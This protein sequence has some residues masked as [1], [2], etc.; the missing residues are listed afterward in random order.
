[1]EIKTLSHWWPVLL[2]LVG[3]ERPLYFATNETH[4]ISR[5]DAK[6][7]IQGQLAIN[8][9][10]EN[11]MSYQAS[12][13][14]ALTNHLALR[15]SWLRGGDDSYSQ[16]FD[17]GRFD[18]AHL[19]IGGLYKIPKWHLSGSTWLGYSEGSVLNVNKVSFASESL[20]TV[21]LTNGYRR[22]FVEQQIR[23]HFQAIEVFGTLSMGNSHLFGFNLTGEPREGSAFLRDY[24]FHKNNRTAFF[25]NLGWG[26]SAGSRNIRVQF[27]VD[28]LFG[29]GIGQFNQANSI[30]FTTGL[31]MRLE[32]SHWLTAFR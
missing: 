3:C 12:A 15:G 27:R 20:E 23:Y 22:L 7:D 31:C 14:V 32:G 25:G 9:S 28:Q 18:A 19:G 17:Y 16:Q 6:G 4:M 24:T 21:R 5:L 26:I 2:L 8:Q 30:F 13:A 10:L 1:M 29:S 11:I